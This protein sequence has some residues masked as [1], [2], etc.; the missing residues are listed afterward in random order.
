MTAHQ[1]A[2]AIGVFCVL[3]AV[4]VGVVILVG[5]IRQGGVPLEDQRTEDIP[6]YPEGPNWYDYI[7]GRTPE[8]EEE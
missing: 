5:W 2:D 4:A 7:H 6:P 3:L 1:F 8:R